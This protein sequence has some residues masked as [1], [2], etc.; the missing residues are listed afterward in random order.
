MNL[1][2][3][4]CL[5][6]ILLAI[7]VV[8]GCD[9]DGLF[10]TIDPPAPTTD[11]L[12]IADCY[13]LRDALEAFAAENGGVY[14]LGPNDQ[15]DAGNPFITFLPGDT[16]L[17]NQYTEL[18]TAPV[19]NDPYWPGEIG[20]D[21]FGDFVQPRGYRVVGLGR[22][23]ELA[24]LEKIAALDPHT[25]TYHDSVITNCDATVAAAEEFSRQAGRC[26]SDVAADALPSGLTMMDFLPNGELLMNPS[27][28]VQDSPVDGMTSEAGQIGY[29]AIDRNGDGTNDGYLVFAMGA[30]G[31]TLIMVRA[32]ESPE[33]EITRSAVLSVRGDVEEFAS[34][35]GGEYP[36][37]LSE[38][39]SCCYTN[40]YTGS[41]ALHQGLATLR[42]E[43]G[44]L[45]IEEGGVVVG[46]I[47][48]A[49]GLFNEE[50]ERFEVLPN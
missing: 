49:L 17:T 3:L 33:D 28:N 16:Q 30:D 48:N 42:G 44:Y 5:P 36:R 40:P 20:V 29:Q 45:P 41:E 6:I 47:I 34:Y 25:V 31:Y 50:L 46:Y 38:Y 7:L 35:N 14:P 13:A 2:N 19:W 10:Q 26:P 24:R 27:S 11:E 39:G 12:I 22:Y 8:S 4:R 15:S 1:M 32:R 23:G 43:I 37:D 9:G 18:A 21:Y